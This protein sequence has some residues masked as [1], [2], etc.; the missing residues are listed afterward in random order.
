MKTILFILTL[1][2]ANIH[3]A[4]SYGEIKGTV[5][6]DEYNE[7][8]IFIIVTAQCGQ[9]IIRVTTDIDG[10]YSIKPVFPGTYTLTFNRYGK[11]TTGTSP[12]VVE[13][14][15]IAFVPKQILPREVDYCICYFTPPYQPPENPVLNRTDILESVNKFQ[16]LELAVGMSSKLSETPT[17]ELSVRGG[18]ANTVQFIEGVKSREI[19]SLP[20]SSLKRVTVYDSFIPANFG[21]A[22]GAVIVIETL[23]YFDLVGW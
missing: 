1:F 15:K 22:T 14:D 7:P 19:H 3:Y 11:E 9:E 13:A 5:W 6:D 17:G 23:G 20:S 18:T 10:N 8:A 4:Q 21:D 2:A 16:L 12:I